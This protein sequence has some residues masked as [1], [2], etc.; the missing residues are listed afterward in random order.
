MRPLPKP[1]R[2]FL[3]VERRNNDAWY[4]A[5]RLLMTPALRSRSSLRAIHIRQQV[6]VAAGH[7]EPERVRRRLHDA[8]EVHLADALNARFAEAARASDE[9]IWRIRRLDLDLVVNTSWDENELAD[10]WATEC[11]RA[12]THAIE[13]GGDGV[14]VVRFA[15]PA[16]FLASFL[17]DVANGSCWSKWWYGEFTG[18]RL[19]TRAA[20]I[21]TALLRKPLVGLQALATLAPSAMVLVIAELTRQD[22]RVVVDALCAVLEDRDTPD[23]SAVLFAMARRDT[24]PVHRDDEERWV[25]R[26]LAESARVPAARPSR[27]FVAL[28]HA[29]A[30]LASLTAGAGE[31]MAVIAHA[32]RLGDEVALQV[33]AFPDDADCLAPLLSL[34]A[35]L[36]MEILTMVV[37]RDV[38]DATARHAPSSE[39]E[40]MPVAAPLLLAESVAAM[41]F[42]GATLGMPDIGTAGDPPAQCA[43]AAALLRLWVMATA[44]GGERAVRVLGDPIVRRLSGVGTQIATSDLVRWLGAR[45]ATDVQQLERVNA[46]WLWSRGAV[47]MGDWLLV[48]SQDRNDR[49]TVVLLDAARGH[50]L[51]QRDASLAQSPAE[52]L[53]WF[54]GSM[55][56]RTP[57]RV[58]CDTYESRAV[59]QEMP[60]TVDAVLLPEIDDRD[61]SDRSQV[62]RRLDRLAD[63]LAWIA[64]PVSLQVPAEVERALYVI[65]QGTL[66]T[67]AWRMPGFARA[68]LPHLWANFLAVDAQVVVGEHRMVATLSRPPLAMIVSM[69]GL[70]HLSYLLPWMTPSA[71]KLFPSERA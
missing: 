43:S 50:W 21:R 42:E 16:S 39:F 48:H 33:V 17:S 56:E 9:T 58:W 36:R 14:S 53:P 22:A 65:A 51:V 37:S 68:T 69:T 55:V 7:P 4:H 6:L 59:L 3:S 63:E 64:L 13:T 70:F 29:M 32:I 40:W 1:Y 35:S 54:N 52:L 5:S 12:V 31:R 11:R 62:Q 38:V 57:A 15:S 28:A 27:G 61:T 18:L 20:A 46:E 34:P 10:A 71:V 23:D 44:C 66:R 49:P 2:P 47:G 8:L 30:R 19:L 67:L 41:P 26:V 25:L 60:L 45:T 24:L